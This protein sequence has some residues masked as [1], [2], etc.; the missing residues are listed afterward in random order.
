MDTQR[1]IL[2]LVFFGGILRYIIG[3]PMYGLLNLLWGHEL[4]AR[5]FAM[6]RMF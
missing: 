2:F 6:M 4:A 3:V 1:L 5:I